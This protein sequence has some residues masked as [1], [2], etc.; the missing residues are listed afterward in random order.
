MPIVGE[1]DQV[2][3]GQRI[4]EAPE[5]KLG[6]HIHASIDGK[7]SRIDESSIWIERL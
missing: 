6:A 2:H 4:A 3:I 1:R 5:G 7:V